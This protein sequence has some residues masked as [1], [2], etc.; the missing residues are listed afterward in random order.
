MKSKGIFKVCKSLMTVPIP[1]LAL[2]GYA[3]LEEF[4]V[5]MLTDGTWKD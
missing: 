2:P 1:G 4:S 5:L 3:V